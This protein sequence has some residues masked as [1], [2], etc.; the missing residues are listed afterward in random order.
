M[1]RP[2]WATCLATRWSVKNAP[3]ALTATT[4]RILF[5]DV[6][7]RLVDEFDSSVHD[8]DVKT[9]EPLHRR[10]KQP[11]DVGHLRHFA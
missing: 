7:H 6:D 11:L 2:L 10:V 3:F 9:T 5:A 1:M 8:D 4:C